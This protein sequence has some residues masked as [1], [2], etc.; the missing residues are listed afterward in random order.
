MLRILAF[1]PSKIAYSSARIASFM[2]DIVE[3]ILLN[4][5]YPG[6]MDLVFNFLQVAGKLLCLVCPHFIIIE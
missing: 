3:H 6:Q 4:F 5:G 1:G 2:F